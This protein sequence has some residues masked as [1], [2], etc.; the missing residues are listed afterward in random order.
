MI[1]S[2][3]SNFDPFPHWNQC[4]WQEFSF[5]AVSPGNLGDESLPS[6]IQGRSPGM[7][8]GGLHPPEAES[9][10]RHC[11]QILTMEM[12]KIRKFLNN[13]LP[14]TCPVCFTVGGVKHKPKPS[15]AT[16]WNFCSRL[17]RDWTTRLKLPWEISFRPC[18]I[19]CS[20]REPVH[21]AD[22]RP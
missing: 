10:C 16:V 21:I 6:G 14:D 22:N 4:W 11:L 3:E 17:W 9:V 20:R 13:S 18:G 1:L 2:L 5:G 12:I 8:S 15:D 19:I 7:G